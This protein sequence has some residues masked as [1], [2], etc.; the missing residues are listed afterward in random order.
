MNQP[1]PPAP[2]PA[3][4]ESRE[5]GNDWLQWI[6]EQRLR[7]CTPE[8]MLATMTDTGLDAH[9]CSRSIRDAEAHPFF[10]AAQRMLQLPR[11]LESVLG[12]LQLLWESD[13]GFAVVEKR[14]NVS[15]DEMMT[16]YVRGC[17]PLVLT[18]VAADWPAMTR[19][20]PQDLKARFGHIDVE[21]QTERNAAGRCLPSR[22]RMKRTWS[23]VEWKWQ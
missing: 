7:G 10:Q 22:S 4:R 3:T 5:L 12:N 13:P 15:V 11:K 14:A 23:S 8:S 16:R 20:S 9:L 18:D 19:W 2:R 17:R 21:I 1:L 6:A